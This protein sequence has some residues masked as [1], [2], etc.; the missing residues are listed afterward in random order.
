VYSPE[1][2]L[3][4]LKRS[5]GR[6]DGGWDRITW[7]EAL[8]LVADRIRGYLADPG[9]LSIMHYQRTGSWGATKLLSRRFWNLLGGV[10][11]TSGSLC[12]GAARAG[13]A[14]DFGVRA[15]HDPSDMLNSRLVLLWG[16]NPMATNLHTV[17]ILKEIRKRGGRVVLI[18][19]V[20]SESA[21]FCDE[22]VQPRVATD[23]ELAMAMAKVILEEGLEDRAYLE[24]H[25]HGFA[26]Y[27]AL[28]DAR[29]LAELAAACELTEEAIRALAREYATTRPASVLL[30]WGLNKY[31]HSA[32]MFRCVDA[33]GAL[34]GHIGVPGG[35][36]S[37][38]YNTQRHFDKTVEA[39]DRAMHHRA[40][41]EPLLGRG[42]RSRH[43]H[44]FVARHR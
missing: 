38:G 43:P 34:C 37:H 40:I 4:P 33:L 8:D 27:R 17:P 19:P 3:H 6:P 21:N 36:V 24:R 26:E 18:D 29:P 7:D 42:L 15:G 31:Q 28:L 41:P 1:R 39:A 16:R 23:A 11:T 10:T 25:A 2:Q 13:Q 30:G 35:G 5:N 44:V 22:H 9:P 20:R 32:E 12:S 14:L